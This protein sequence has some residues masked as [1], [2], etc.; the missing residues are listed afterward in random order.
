MAPPAGSGPSR[1]ISDRDAPQRLRGEKRRPRRPGRRRRRTCVLN[2][3]VGL[4]VAGRDLRPLLGR[5]EK[6]QG[7]HGPSDERGAILDRP[8][9]A[10]RSAAMLRGV[11]ADAH[12]CMV[13]HMHVSS[14]GSSTRGPPDRRR[15]ARTAAGSSGA[16]R[17]RCGRARRRAA[18]ARVAHRR[19]AP[20]PPRGPPA[21]RGSGAARPRGPAAARSAAQ[22][23]ARSDA[24]RC[25]GHGEEEAV[26][27]VQ[28]SAPADGEV[29][30]VEQRESLPADA[31]RHPV[32]AQHRVQRWLERAPVQERNGR[33]GARRR[34]GAAVSRRRRWRAVTGER[35]A[36]LVDVV[37]HA[38]VEVVEALAAQR[39]G[40]VVARAVAVAL[41][42]VVRQPLA[43]AH[44]QQVGVELER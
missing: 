3:G 25:R 38:L 33:A 41:V 22:R 35:G 42:H 8:L 24:S 15:P 44:G 10:R 5:V 21:A 13:A 16:R 40:A 1:L 29:V 36:E 32:R 23:A 27:R 14:T 28:C 20:P 37:G 19:A 6:G 7:E 30:A 2:E 34:G 4:T 43:E 26:E 9:W 12:A 31:A 17:R 11:H 39:G 18:R